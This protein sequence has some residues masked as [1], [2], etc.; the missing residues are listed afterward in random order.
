VSTINTVN[1]WEPTVLGRSKLDG[2]WWAYLVQA[3]FDMPGDAPELMGS[4][5]ILDGEA[6]GIGGSVPN[7]PAR[8]IS[9]GEP[10]QILVSPL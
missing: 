8:P 4:R 10:I 2:R 9:K 3:P 6:F 5:V 1:V 7:V